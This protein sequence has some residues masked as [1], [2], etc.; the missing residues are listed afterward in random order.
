MKK[1]KKLWLENRI[2]FVLFIITLICA[3]I[4]LGVILKYFFGA[5]KSSYGER[6]DGIETVLVSDTMKS[7]FIQSLTSDE[8]ITNVAINV[9]GKIIYIYLTFKEGTSLVEAQSKALASLQSFEEP[10]LN[11]YDF[12][13]TIKSNAT[14]DNE[15]FLLM[16]ARNVNGSGLVWNNNTPIETDSE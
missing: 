15:G 7:D 3:C 2:L 8:Q 1:I 9:K 16:G 10:Y 11:F 13:F 14:E 6:L 4:I 12:H 5:T